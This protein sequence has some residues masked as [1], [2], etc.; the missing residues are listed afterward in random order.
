MIPLKKSSPQQ[1]RK[2]P[3]NQKKGNPTPT[4]LSTN[5]W[6]ASAVK[7]RSGSSEASLCGIHQN[8]A[9]TN[10][11]TKKLK[12]R[13][14]EILE[15]KQRAAGC[16]HILENNM[17]SSIVYN[18]R[19]RLPFSR[20]TIRLQSSCGHAYGVTVRRRKCLTGSVQILWIRQH[21]RLL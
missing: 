14:I 3:N 17:R 15:N 18:T 7:S 6:N 20:F 9:R 1:R 2:S 8:Q 11:E 5:C 13:L 12:K 10:S 16:Q 4:P 21:C 19:W